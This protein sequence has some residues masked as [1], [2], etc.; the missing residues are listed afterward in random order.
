MHLNRN[1]RSP[2]G[3]G[4]QSY[5]T[6]TP[7]GDGVQTS[8]K[9]NTRAFVTVERQTRTKR[10]HHLVVTLHEEPAQASNFTHRQQIIMLDVRLVGHTAGE[11]TLRRRS[12]CF[13][14]YQKGSITHLTWLSYGSRPTSTLLRFELLYSSD[15]PRLWT[16]QPFHLVFCCTYKQGRS[17]TWAKK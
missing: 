8:T 2:C 11:K 13:K 6:R 14:S 12:T 17:P 9:T 7:P 3:T 15:F 4:H 5:R 16:I 10:L 1:P